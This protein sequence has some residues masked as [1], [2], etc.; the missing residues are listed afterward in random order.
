LDF[1]PIGFICEYEL[2]WSKD[3]SSVSMR[4]NGNNKTMA[5]YLRS[6]YYVKELQFFDLIV[7]GHIDKYKL[8]V[9]TDYFCS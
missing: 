8:F 6:I 4:Y 9:L 7:F 2:W 5:V 3:I 1:R